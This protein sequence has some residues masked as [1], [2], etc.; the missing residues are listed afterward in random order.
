MSEL[1]RIVVLEAI[2]KER[3]LQDSVWKDQEDYSN[4]WWHVIA[5]EKSGE[6]AKEIYQASEKQLLRKL[7]VLCAVYFAWA[8][9]LVKNSQGDIE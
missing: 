4:E 8:E 5:T 3:E 9:M 6:V 2:L 7:I 1:G